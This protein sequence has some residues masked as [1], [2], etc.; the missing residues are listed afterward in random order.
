MFG[1]L[2]ILC[3]Q[4]YKIILWHTSCG[5]RILEDRLNLV[6]RQPAKIHLAKTKSLM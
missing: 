1:L 2:D 3:I 4:T 6:F 5:V